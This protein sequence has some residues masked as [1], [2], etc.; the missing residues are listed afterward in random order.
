[1]NYPFSYTVRAYDYDVKQ[2]YYTESGI[3]LCSD[4]ADAALQIKEYFGD[5]F[6]EIQHLELYDGTGLI[7]LSSA[8][9]NAVKDCFNT[10]EI[11]RKYETELERE[12]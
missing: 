1:M 6:V 8:A 11:F 9:F 10:E 3:G 2:E 7:N 12:V 4:L 5:E